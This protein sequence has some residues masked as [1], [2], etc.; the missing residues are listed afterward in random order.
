MHGVKINNMLHVMEPEE[1]GA[2]IQPLVSQLLQVREGSGSNVYF[3]L[4]C[5]FR[6]VVT[7]FA[8]GLSLTSTERA[9]ARGRGLQRRR[10]WIYKEGS[11]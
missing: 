9:S 2:G 3:I 11:G 4:G 8:S 1:P 5:F 7:S 10:F 6:P